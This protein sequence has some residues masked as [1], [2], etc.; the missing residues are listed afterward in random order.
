MRTASAGRAPR[1]ARAVAR[2]RQAAVLRGQNAVGAA[3][4]AGRRSVAR[5][6]PP[7]EV[8]GGD[9]GEL[10]AVCHVQLGIDVRQV[11]FDSAAAHEQPGADVGVIQ[12]VDDQA[13]APARRGQ[14][15]PATGG[16]SARAAGTTDIGDAS[17]RDMRCPSAQAEANGSLPRAVRAPA[18]ADSHARRRTAWRGYPSAPRAASLAPSTRAAPGGGRKRRQRLQ[19]VDIRTCAA[20]APLGSPA[21]RGA[22]RLHGCLRH[23]SPGGTPAARVRQR[24]RAAYPGGAQSRAPARGVVGGC[25][26]AKR[27]QAAPRPGNAWAARK[28]GAPR[29]V[30]ARLT[31]KPRRG[32]FGLV[33][34]QMQCAM[35]PGRPGTNTSPSAPSTSRSTG[36]MISRA[37]FKVAAE[38]VDQREH[39]SGTADAQVVASGSATRT[40]SSASR[41]CASEVTGY[42][43]RH[44]P[45]CRVRSRRSRGDV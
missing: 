24:A 38:R 25:R 3:L 8:A 4:H 19:T 35:V 44:R 43:A 15:G 9:G 13:Y 14:A 23:H 41:P 32:R 26:L 1:V 21:L 5:H 34:Q 31:R 42:R 6:L 36:C 27:G 29:S 10:G 30:R 17:S 20:R 28:V 40:A 33:A 2:P 39:R 16:S 11:G 22:G 7:G 37:A 12:A 18:S 45:G